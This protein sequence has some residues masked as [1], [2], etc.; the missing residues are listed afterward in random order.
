MKKPSSQSLGISH[1]R[2]Q[3]CPYL[4]VTFWGS[5]HRI[6]TCKS[7]PI[8]YHAHLWCFCKLRIKDVA[9]DG[10][11]IFSDDTDIEVLLHLVIEVS[12]SGIV[13][14]K[15][16]AFAVLHVGFARDFMITLAHVLKLFYDFRN[17][18]VNHNRVFPSLRMVVSMT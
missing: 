18:V 2:T 3:R 11:V 15:T 1:Q 7:V 5:D 17:G 4:V 13:K 12:A 8:N 14:T 6:A 16:K 9:L 10:V